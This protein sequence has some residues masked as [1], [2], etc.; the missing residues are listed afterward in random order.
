MEDLEWT[1]DP[2]N[3]NAP[4]RV[5]APHSGMIDLTLTPIY[6]KTTGLNLG[7]FATGGTCVLGTWKGT[8]RAGENEIVVDRMIGWAEEFA[9][10][11]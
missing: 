8:I 3:W 1:Y 11:W 6:P 9:H 7:L 4:W 10:R 5:R 2:S